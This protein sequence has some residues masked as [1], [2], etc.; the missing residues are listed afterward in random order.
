MKFDPC[1]SGKSWL[2][3]LA[4]SRNMDSFSPKEKNS[5]KTSI[6]VAAIVA[7]ALAAPIVSAQ[8]TSAPAKLVMS[9]DMEQ[10]ISQ[11]QEKLEKMQQQM[12]KLQ[13][14]TDPM[15]RRKLMQEHVQ[16]M[17]ENMKTIRDMGGPTMDGGRRGGMAIDGD[18][19]A[20]GGD[21]TQ[22]HEMM[23]EHSDVMQIL[24]D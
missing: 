24:V 2:A 22:Q 9:T 19:G 13:T 12:E 4:S 11:M 1:V 17:R 7:C 14:T 21:M 15:E 8:E 6:L 23:E 10:Q 5:M 18:K 16:A 20:A 3:V